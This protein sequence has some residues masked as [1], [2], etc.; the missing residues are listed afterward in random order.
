MDCR[1]SYFSAWTMRRSEPEYSPTARPRV[2]AVA[3]RRH[4]AHRF[5]STLMTRHDDSGSPQASHTGGVIGTMAFQQ[6]RQTGP[7][8]GSSSGRSQAAQA[9]ASRTA[10][11]PSR[12]F[13]DLD[14]FGVTP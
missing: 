6:L 3:L 7:S 4:L 2:R 1:P 5:C 10:N 12:S 11:R 8:V 9:G 14:P 13:A